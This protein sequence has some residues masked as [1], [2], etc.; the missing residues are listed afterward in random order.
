M[1]GS[2]LRRLQELV[3][4]LCSRATKEANLLAAAGVQINVVSINLPAAR[5]N[6]ASRQQLVTAT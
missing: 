3:V 2:L 6:D 5:Q 4:V 1:T